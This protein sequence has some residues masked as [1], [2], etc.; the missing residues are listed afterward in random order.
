MN[1]PNASVLRTVLGVVE[2]PGDVLHEAGHLALTPAAERASLH[3]NVAESQPE[4]AGDEL[5]VM[6][7]SYAACRALE[8]PPEVVFHPTGYHGQSAWIL[9]NYR[10]HRFV[11]LPLLA[12]MGL[13]TPEAFPGMTRWVRA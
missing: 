10:Q 7:W 5:A 6:L 12:S 1:R 8:L 11:G 9:D 3:G 2:H 13:T 4:R